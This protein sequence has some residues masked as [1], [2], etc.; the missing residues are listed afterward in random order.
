MKHGNSLGLSGAFTTL[1]E[2]KVLS[3]KRLSFMPICERLSQYF[4][5]WKLYNSVQAHVGLS[6]SLGF[7]WMESGMTQQL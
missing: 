2:T 6:A 5:S 3:Y 7:T 1:P 4:Q